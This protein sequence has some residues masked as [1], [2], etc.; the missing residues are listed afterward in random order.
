MVQVKLVVA[1]GKGVAFF[2]LRSKG[3][4]QERDLVALWAIE[5]DSMFF[6]RF[7][8]GPRQVEHCMCGAITRLRNHSCRHSIGQGKI[9]VLAR[10]DENAED[11]L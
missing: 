1:F 2:A 11:Y 9:Y 3:S 7:A 4:G 10:E 8:Q 6:V 5:S